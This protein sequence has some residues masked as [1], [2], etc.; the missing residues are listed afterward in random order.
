MRLGGG[1][2]E[3]HGSGAPGWVRDWDEAFAL[4]LGRCRA[5]PREA[6]HECDGL[7]RLRCQS[8]FEFGQEPLVNPIWRDTRRWKPVV[9]FGGQPHSLSGILVRGA[10]TLS[11]CRQRRDLDRNIGESAKGGPAN[12]VIGGGRV[13]SN[14]PKRRATAR[15]LRAA[16]A[17]LPALG[18]ACEV[19]E[20]SVRRPRKKAPSSGFSRKPISDSEPPLSLEKTLMA[21][22]HLWWVAWERHSPVLGK[23]PGPWR[24]NWGGKSCAGN[25]DCR[26]GDFNKFRSPALRPRSPDFGPLRSTLQPQPPVTLGTGF[27]ELASAPRSRALVGP[28]TP[29]ERRRDEDA[30]RR[31]LSLV[32]VSQPP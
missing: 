31:P 24:R 13:R 4:V 25:D 30:G 12:P 3:L 26:L 29:L 17:T 23:E 10:L 22:C 28:S 21:R 19:A 8:R 11:D 7:A 2:V 16:G 18:L 1:E 9:D 6:S 15:L 32:S 5:E 20:G 27:C 14:A